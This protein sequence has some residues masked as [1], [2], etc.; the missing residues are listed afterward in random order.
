[1]RLNELCERF[2]LV[3]SV[4]KKR[5]KNEKVHVIH[6]YIET[7]ETDGQIRDRH[8]KENVLVRQCRDIKKRHRHEG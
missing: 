6:T 7:R 2:S 3:P 5:K 8:S 4:R 1:M